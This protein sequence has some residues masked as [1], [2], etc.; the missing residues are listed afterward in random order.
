MKYPLFS[1]VEN[2]PPGFEFRS[3]LSQRDVR[4]AVFACF[5]SSVEAAEAALQPFVEKIA[6]VIVTYGDEFIWERRAS[7]LY[8]LVVPPSMRHYLGDALDSY[9]ELVE[10][11]QVQMNDNKGQYLEFARSV[12]DRKRLS[13]D[14]ARSR[15]SLLEEISERRSAEKALYESEARLSSLIENIQMGVLFADDSRRILYVNREFCKLFGMGAPQALIGALCERAAEETKRLFSDP[16]GFT[17]RI[18]GLLEAKEKVLAEEIGLNNGR[19]FERDYVPVWA[20]E[21]HRGHLW[22][23]RD[24][25][26]RRRTEEEL[27]KVDK[28]E[29][30]G[31]LAGGIAHDFNNILTAILAN[32]S[33]AK[34]RLDKDEDIFKKLH[35]AERATIRAVDLTQQLL[36]FAK[37]GAPI[38]EMTSIVELIRDSA[39]F[40]LRGSNISCE[41]DLQDNLWL[42]EVDEGQINQVINN[43][44]INAAQAMPEGGIIKMGAENVIV[45][46]EHPL[47]LHGGK[48]V[49]ISV[50]DH[51]TGITEEHLR[52]I[53]DPYFTTKQKGSGLGL[54]VTYSIIKNHDGYI[55]AESELG[56]GTTFHVYLPA[57][58]RPLMGK[59][60]DEETLFPGKGKILV[61]DD[62]DIVREV[63]GEM[64]LALGYSVA[65]AAEGAGAV[66]M[67]KEA[68]DSGSPFDA[69]IMDLT[70]PG[71]MGGKEAIKKLVE[72]DPAVKAIVSSGY[73][74]DSIMADFRRYG[75]MGVM[76]KPYEV[77]QLGRELRRVIGAEA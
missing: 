71:G 39:E 77:A 65:F 30:V 18:R 73:S 74:N 53:F 60:S 75:F 36:T 43:L 10:A 62:E 41:F 49:K 19:V 33:L 57:A 3:A 44:I 26:G 5:A 48:Y 56:F 69:V 24:I 51:G 61:M 21:E 1:L 38:R 59:K 23:Y 31:I 50:E 28:L 15:E 17:R 6:G 14:F 72:F 8:H 2:P 46:P 67:Y 40:A 9:L 55:T 42:A 34:M 52:R 63:I 70:I 29:S 4:P 11:L 45:K 37:G 16:E 25:T 64:L 22:V 47:P 66:E 12:E 68:R 76:T 32:I 20:G 7:L 35:A 54:T 13:S 58:E 27:L